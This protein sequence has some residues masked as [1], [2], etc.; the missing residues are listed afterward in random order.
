ME[1]GAQA[2]VASCH[3]CRI[4]K[5]KKGLTPEVR[6]ELYERPFRVL[7]IDAFGPISPAPEGY[8]H[9]Y[10][11]ACPFTRFASLKAE[12]VGTEELWATC[13]VEDVCST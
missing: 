13:F 10:H 5:P 1:S 6:H 7:F 4:T 9:I 3:M 8:T 12:T 11:C 2:W